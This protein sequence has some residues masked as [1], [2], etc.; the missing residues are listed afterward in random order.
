MAHAGTALVLADAAPDARAAI[1]RAFQGA[2]IEPTLE[3]AAEDAVRLLGSR[4]FDALVVHLGTPGAA[5]FCLKARG[6]LLRMRVPIVALVD[7]VDEDDFARAYRAGADEVLPL[8]RL[9]LLTARLASLPRSVLPQPGQP[10]G[11]ALVADPDRLRAE[12][13]ERLLRDAGFRVELAHDAFAAK[14]LT[15][16]PAFKLAVVDAALEPPLGLLRT[17]R[18]RGSRAAWVVRAR[19]EQVDAL[20]GELGAAE[21]VAVVSAYGP[22][23]DV[24]FESNR[25]LDPRQRDGRIGARL[26]HGGIL[27]LRWPG[28]PGPDLGYSYNVSSAGIFVRTLAEP[29]GEDVEVRATVPGTSTRVRLEARVVWR[30]EFGATRR[31]PVPAGFGLRLTGGDLA[32]WAA[33]APE[34]PSLR[35]LPPRA[36]ESEPP[37]GGGPL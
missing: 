28:M 24:L 36:S 14:L 4:R 6:R 26:L 1:E 33:A 23:E 35:P 30:R 22:P 16:R 37:S 27:E 29:R 20:R 8:D 19:P 34:A 12:V 25:L 7:G 31:E 2:G 3:T 5:G 15:A 9:E 17:A 18:A 21:S 13:V 32:S 10:R 11:D